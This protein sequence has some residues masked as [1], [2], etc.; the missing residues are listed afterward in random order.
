MRNFFGI[1]FKAG[2][3]TKIVWGKFLMLKFLRYEHFPNTH[4][5]GCFFHFCQCVMRKISS[6]G[7]KERYETDVDFALSIRYLAALAF[8]PVSRILKNSDVLP[9]ESE[10]VID[11]FED[12]WIS[13]PQN[14]SRRRATKFLLEWWNCY[15]K[16]RA[17][18]PK[19][20]NT[21]EGWL[22]VLKAHLK[23]HTP[24]FSNHW[25]PSRKKKRLWKHHMNRLL[26]AS[27]PPRER[28]TSQ[29]PI[30]YTTS[31]KHM[32]M[33]IWMTRSYA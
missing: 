27:L 22:E 18:A 5:D 25:K 26:P 15:E 4:T 19:T 33:T 24:I 8:V 23:R 3:V 20:N 16:V 7:L 21:V 9:A 1:K 10:Q 6:C 11:Y 14:R 31:S 13:R 2:L 28:S 30:A 32:M 29:Q 12:T 17:R